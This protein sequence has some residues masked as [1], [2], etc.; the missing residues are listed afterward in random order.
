M[1]HLYYKNHNSNGIIMFCLAFTLFPILFMLIS[2]VAKEYI[3]KG[4]KKLSKLFGM[5]P[6]IAAVTLI[7][8]AERGIV[9][10]LQIKKKKT[11]ETSLNKGNPKVL[12]IALASFYGGFLFSCSLVVYNAR[13]ASKIDI[14]LPK[15]SIL[16]E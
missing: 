5:T 15:L 14:D 6:S 8:F 7:P 1:I 2:R 16:K 11:L 13:K 12:Y 4:I 3:S 10:I 9:K